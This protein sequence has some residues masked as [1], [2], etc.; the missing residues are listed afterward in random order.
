MPVQWIILHPRNIFGLPVC[1]TTLRPLTKNSAIH[2]TL[3]RRLLMAY[4]ALVIQCVE[5]SIH[6]PRL[7][8][9]PLLSQCRQTI[10][11]QLAN[12]ELSVVWLARHALGCSPDHL[13]RAFHQHSGMRLRRYIEE[14][15]LE[16]AIE[17]LFQTSN[18]KIAAIAWSC[19]F[20]SPS[21]FDRIFMKLQEPTLRQSE[22]DHNPISLPFFCERPRNLQNGFS[23]S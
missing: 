13:S 14:C 23:D 15:R 11:S 9:P 2:V 1:W 16:Q 21:Y 20:S 8:D 7:G 4:L 3:I 17:L 19:G 5:P 6:R 12:P 10:H 22:R 18:L